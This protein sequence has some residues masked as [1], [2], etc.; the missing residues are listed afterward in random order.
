M[1]PIQVSYTIPAL[2]GGHLDLHLQ[3][4][5]K[6]ECLPCHSWGPGL[7][8]SY[9]LHF[10]HSG[11]GTFFLNGQP[12]VRSAGQGF[13]IFPDT[14]VHYE[15]DASDP[16][17]YSW[18]GFRGLL[19]KSL[20]YRASLSAAHPLYEA[21]DS[22]IMTSFFRELAESYDQPHADVLSQGIL[23]RTIAELIRCSPASSEKT[24]STF[25]KEAYLSQATD[26][27]EN[28]F[29]QKISVLEIARSVGLN[30]T[31]L[32]GLFKSQYGVS[33]QRFLLEYRMNR[34][35]SLLKEPELS[36]SDIA[37]SVGYT[38]PFLFSKMFKEVMGVSPRF[39]KENRK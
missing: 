34:A 19:A 23:Y 31:Y 15:A 17:T 18:V 13:V 28:N 33:L 1:S 39:Y 7:R 5:G 26:F 4:F 2:Q 24:T 9:I 27:I 37:R 35:A 21:S 32:S 12:C 6:E 30:R 22:E 10:I 14:L 25:S 11:K 8:D 38:D 36:V 20:L 16:W 29:S 3:F